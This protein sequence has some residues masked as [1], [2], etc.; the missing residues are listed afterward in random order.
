M[1]ASEDIDYLTFSNPVFCFLGFWH[2]SGPT[3][4]GVLT[5]VTKHLAPEAG[6]KLGDLYHVA[7]DDGDSEDL[8]SKEVR[9]PRSG[10]NI[11]RA[12]QAKSW[13]DHL[14]I[15]FVASSTTA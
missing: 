15:P 13:L 9:L 2:Q 5:Q 11:V 8:D 12:V 7:Y 3:F 10:N 4:Y 6:D 1:R 14:Q